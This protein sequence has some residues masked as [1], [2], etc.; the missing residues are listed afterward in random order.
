MMHRNTTKLPGET[1][2]NAQFEKIAEP[3]KEVS[4]LTVK[5]FETVVAMQLKNVE[6]NTRIGIEQAKTA[7]SINDADGW[8]GY[9]QAQAEITQQ[10]ND[11]MVESARNVVELGNA[12]TTEIQRIVKSAFNV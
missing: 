10:Y 7:A 6:E 9:L 11:R 1:E 2:M 8:K 5:N 12:Y 3:I 4:N